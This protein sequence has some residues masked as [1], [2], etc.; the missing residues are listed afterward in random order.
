[1]VLGVALFAA[2]IFAFSSRS[3]VPGNP[4]GLFPGSDKVA[5]FLEFAAF[6]AILL[7]ALTSADWRPWDAPLAASLGIVYGLVD[8]LHQILVPGRTPD[9]LD[10]VADAAGVLLAVAIL[11]CLSHGR[12][13]I[14]GKNPSAYPS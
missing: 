4:G 1:M 8:E 12:S 9:V 5:H 2:L 6:G 3:D 7:L 11:A 14:A 13:L 10:A